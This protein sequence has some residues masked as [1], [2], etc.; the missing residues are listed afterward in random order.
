VIAHE[1]RWD[2]ER[3]RDEGRDGRHAHGHLR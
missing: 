3:Q 1:H 2:R